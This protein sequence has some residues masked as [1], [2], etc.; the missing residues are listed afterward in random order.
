MLNS[1]LDAGEENIVNIK[2]IPYKK[3]KKTDDI[4]KKNQLITCEIKMIV[5]TA[6]DSTVYHI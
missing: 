6:G 2:K 5:Y 3:E 4:T 1:E